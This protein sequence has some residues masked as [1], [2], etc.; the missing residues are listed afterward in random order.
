MRS[1]WIIRRMR[2]RLRRGK[3]MGVHKVNIF[4]HFC[5]FMLK[6]NIC[7]RTLAGLPPFRML[8]RIRSHQD[9]EIRLR[10]HRRRRRTEEH[11]KCFCWARNICKPSVPFLLLQIGAMPCTLTCTTQ[12]PPT[13]RRN[14]LLGCS[15][16]FR[17]RIHAIA[18]VLKTSFQPINCFLLQLD[19]TVEILSLSA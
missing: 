18:L 3:K 1:E 9:A 19:T 16:S 12:N 14:S 2:G 8:S 5:G 13:R 15:F 6:Q 11:L 4:M 17:L 7:T 10:N